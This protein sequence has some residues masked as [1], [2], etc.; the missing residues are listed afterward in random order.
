MQH[1]IFSELYQRDPTIGVGFEMFQTPFQNVLDDWTAGRIDETTLRR[2]S[3]WDERWGFDFRLYRPILEFVRTRHIPAYALNAPQEI[4]RTVGRDGVA[5]LSEEQRAGLPVLDLSN[6]EHRALVTEALGEHATDMSEERFEAM[7][8]AQVIWDETMA[9][10]VKT[11]MWSWPAICTS[12]ADLAS[13]SAPTRRRTALCSPRTWATPNASTLC[14][15][16]TR[17]RRPIFGSSIRQ[18]K[19]SSG[20][21]V[22]ATHVG[23]DACELRRF[24]GSVRGR[25]RRRSA[26]SRRA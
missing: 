22:G 18:Q 15:R 2:E 19:F 8:T 7:Y 5:G 21:A 14:W 3:E 17:E 4:T 16:P 20:V 13:P 24:N 9:R 10:S 11:A 26:S 1:R 25:L 12:A 23:A 6:E